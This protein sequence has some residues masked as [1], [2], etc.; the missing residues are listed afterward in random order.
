MKRVFG[1]LA[2]I[3]LLLSIGLV[4]YLI[5]SPL[6]ALIYT[7]Y[8]VLSTALTLTFSTAYFFKMNDVENKLLNTLVYSVAF[9]PSLIPLIAC[10][11]PDIMETYWRNYISLTFLQLGVGILSA[12]FFFRKPGVNF[13]NVCS[14]L[15]AMILFLFGILIILDA[16]VLRSLPFLLSSSTIVTILFLIALTKRL[17]EVKSF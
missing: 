3:S 12:S 7:P 17:R 9:I 13:V 15:S 14:A 10:F 2:V 8:L 6:L 11:D 4:I 1:L 5:L 16:G